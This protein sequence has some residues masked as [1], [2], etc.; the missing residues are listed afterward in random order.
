MTATPRKR[1]AAA[2]ANTPATPPPAAGN[3]NLDFSKL[4]ESAKPV[5]ELPKVARN[6]AESS[7]ALAQLVLRSFTEKKPFALPAVPVPAGTAPMETRAKA[8]L[9]KIQSAVRRAA[10]QV[11]LGVTIRHETTE[12]GVVVTFIGKAKNETTKK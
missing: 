6:G 5:K 2:K 8:T 7:S 11:D 10:S 3:G 12:A 1:V 9:A 4:A